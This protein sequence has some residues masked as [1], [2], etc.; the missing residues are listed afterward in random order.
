MCSGMRPGA[1]VR[2]PPAVLHNSEWR[3]D[4]CAWRPISARRATGTLLHVHATHGLPLSMRM[5]HDSDAKQ[6]SKVGA[7]MSSELSLPTFPRASLSTNH[8]QSRAVR[9][10]RMT[11]VPRACANLYHRRDQRELAEPTKIA[12]SSATWMNKHFLICL[13]L[14]KKCHKSSLYLSECFQ[15]WDPILLPTPYRAHHILPGTRRPG[16]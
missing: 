11:C 10:S 3:N 15:C 14:K 12:Q 5:V 9:G 8:R 4:G 6:K 7:S 16:A 13:S 2:R 1:D